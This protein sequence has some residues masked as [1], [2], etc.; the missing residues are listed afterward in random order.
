MMQRFYLRRPAAT[1]VVVDGGGGS[2][3]HPLNGQDSGPNPSPCIVPVHI[4]ANLW[5]DRTGQKQNAPL[6]SSHSFVTIAMILTKL[7]SSCVLGTLLCS[8][9]LAFAP[10]PRGG[11]A[12]RSLARPTCLSASSCDHE[13]ASAVSDGRR[14]FLSASAMALVAGCAPMSAQAKGTGGTDYKAVASDIA[15]IVKADPNKGPTL[16]R[17]VSDCLHR[18]SF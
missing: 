14:A 15:A 7:L 5:K 12:S 3:L 13:D 6:T 2:K 16:V 18:M 10:L 1:R 4:F 9:S 8:G 11:V 17:L